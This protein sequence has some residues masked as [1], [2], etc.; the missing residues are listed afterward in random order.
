MKTERSRA[1]PLLSLEQGRLAVG[2]IRAALGAGCYSREVLAEA[3]GHTNAYGGPGARKIAALAQFGL[4]SRRAGLYS[5]TPLAERVSAAEPGTLDGQAALREA[6][7]RPPLFRELLERY[8]AQERVPSQLASVLWKDH[9]ITRKASELAAENFK[10]SARYAGVLDAQGTLRLPQSTRSP[11]PTFS[12][13]SSEVAEG[14]R[15]AE[16]QF[17]FPLTG[18]KVARLALPRNLSRTDLDIIRRQVQLIEDQVTEEEPRY[19]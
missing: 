11:A 17:V 10:L 4:L 1:Y 16:Q 8:A 9:G 13:P 19:E 14:S 15:D 7:Q 6:L 12:A 5:P 18:G 2:E 3:L